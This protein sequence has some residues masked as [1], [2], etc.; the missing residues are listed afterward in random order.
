MAGAPEAGATVCSLLQQ[1]AGGDRSQRRGLVL[2][3]SKVK[4]QQKTPLPIRSTAG[5]APTP[6]PF[7]PQAE[8]SR[9]QRSRS[10]TKVDQPKGAKRGKRS[11]SQSSNSS[12]AACSAVAPEDT[13]ASEKPAAAVVPTKASSHQKLALFKMGEFC[14][15]VVATCVKGTEKLPESRLEIDQRAKLSHCRALLDRV[16]DFISI[17][18]MAAA[19]RKDCKAY[20]LLCEY[21][22]QK[23]RIGLVDCPSYNVYI[24]PPTE[25]YLQELG[26]PTSS[27]VVGIQ[28]PKKGVP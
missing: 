13:A 18:H 3:L 14:C 20:D 21:F 23:D 2:N 12:S 28:V 6:D 9:S 5:T 1:L 8:K 19:K 4:V 27:Y 11:S 25:K 7:P 16:G 10:R 24:V 15:N 22:I 26:L 17:W